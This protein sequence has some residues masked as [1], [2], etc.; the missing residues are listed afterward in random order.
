MKRI[1]ERLPG[2]GSGGLGADG[3]LVI[4][5]IE[6]AVVRDYPRSCQGAGREAWLPG[7]ESRLPTI[8]P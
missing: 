3:V 5:R 6:M 7:L 1:V 4:D 2:L 8:R